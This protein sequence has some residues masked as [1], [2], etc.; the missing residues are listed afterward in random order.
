MKYVQLHV[1]ELCISV[2]TLHGADCEISD[3]HHIH[4]LSWLFPIDKTQFLPTL[5]FYC[6]II[7]LCI[8]Y[9]L[10]FSSFSITQPDCFRQHTRIIHLPELAESFPSW[11][12]HAHLGIITLIQ[13]KITP[14]WAAYPSNLRSISLLSWNCI[15]SFCAEYQNFSYVGRLSLLA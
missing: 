12:Q 2:T 7:F 4:L 10:I 5:Y 13:D 11:Q 15:T 14:N 3:R 1:K 9:N 8:A 6:H